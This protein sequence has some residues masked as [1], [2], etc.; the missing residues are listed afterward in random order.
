MN[1]MYIASGCFWGTE[2]FF[3]KAPGVIRTAVGY[4]GGQVISPTY[5]EV[6]TG[7]TGH[8]EVVEVTYDS[9]LTSFEELLKL[10]FETHDFQQVGGQGP[11]VGPQYES[12]VFYTDHT[13]KE[14]VEKYISLLKEMHYTPATQCRLAST[15]WEAEEYHQQYYEKKGTLP[16]CHSYKKIFK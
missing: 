15:F 2:Y 11:D 3:M 4:M 10:Y 12:V 1:Q 9:T 7:N 13:Q 16:Y 5:K 6:C 8:V 14:L